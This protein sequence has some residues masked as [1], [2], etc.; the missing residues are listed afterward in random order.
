MSR[1]IE[2]G[3]GAQLLPVAVGVDMLGTSWQAHCAADADLRARFPYWR[4]VAGTL[5]VRA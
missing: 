2:R 3:T 5:E 4:E 1:V